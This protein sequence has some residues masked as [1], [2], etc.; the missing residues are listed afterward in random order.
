MGQ[1]SQIYIR[2]NVNYVSNST[3]KNPVTNNYKGLI[4]RYFGWNYG[5]RMVS[6]ARYIIE[7][8]QSEYMEYK[9]FFGDAEK[10]E[11]LKRICE[12]NFDMKDIVF[13]SDILKEVAEDMD[14]DMEYLFNQDNNDGQ[15]F[16]DVTDNEIKYCFMSYYNEGEPMDAERYMKWNKEYEEH[17]DWHIPYEYM[18]QETIDY[19]EENI[20]QINEMAT[21]MTL[22][23]IKAFIEDDYS[24]LLQEKVNKKIL[25]N[26][27]TEVDS[28]RDKLGETFFDAVMEEDNSTYEMSK[29][30]I[31]TFDSCKDD[32]E[33]KVADNM[34]IA[35]CGYSLETLID[36]IKE[37]DKQKHK[38]ESC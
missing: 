23:E 34:L 28:F 5:E 29:S 1:R 37:R 15:L 36:R 11:K 8:I 31:S 13:S 7:H 22:E 16:I 2:Y 35:I 26:A 20:K 18:D 9:W 12:V 3:T 19:T 17:P 21:L 24:Y 38:W 30:I 14:G 10:L 4:A 33:F 32:M 6:R 27:Y 25:D